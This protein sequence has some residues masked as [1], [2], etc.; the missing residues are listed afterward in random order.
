MLPNSL[1]VSKTANNGA[2]TFHALGLFQVD[3]LLSAWKTSNTITSVS[4]KSCGASAES[5]TCGPAAFTPL[6]AVLTWMQII[7]WAAQL[8]EGCQRSSLLAGGCSWLA[9]WQQRVCLCWSPLVVSTLQDSVLKLKDVPNYK[10]CR[11][12]LGAARLRDFSCAEEMR[13]RVLVRNVSHLLQRMK[14]LWLCAAGLDGTGSTASNL[15]CL[16]PRACLTLHLH[17]LGNQSE[18]RVIRR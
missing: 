15:A 1:N 5:P 8:A 16:C 18:D 2:G 4:L 6:L 7:T 12:T 11:G 17:G 13:Q 10:H 14:P 3:L 9:K